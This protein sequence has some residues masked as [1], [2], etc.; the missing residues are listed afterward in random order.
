MF[1]RTLVCLSV[2]LSG[3]FPAAIIAAPV[4][5]DIQSYRTPLSP[6]TIDEDLLILR[7][8]IPELARRM[9][10]AASTRPSR[11]GPDTVD[12][13]LSRGPRPGPSVGQPSESRLLINGDRYLQA[14]ETFLKWR[15]EFET[16]WG[17]TEVPSWEPKAVGRTPLQKIFADP[18]LD[19]RGKAMAMLKVYYKN[20][21]RKNPVSDP[22][23]KPTPTPP[24]EFWPVSDVIEIPE[25]NGSVQFNLRGHKVTVLN[26]ATGEASV[27]PYY[28]SQDPRAWL[29]TFRRQALK[30]GLARAIE[31]EQE[32]EIE[33]A[34][35]PSAA[36]KAK[37]A[38]KAP[39]ESPTPVVEPVELPPQEKP[40]PQ[41]PWG[42]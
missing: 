20:P 36:L 23:L 42:E 29:A 24:P 14:T 26:E 1:S 7:E 5:V 13:R 28:S 21:I 39:L 10:P 12:L 25:V 33:R 40:K 38:G 17:Q 16:N 30:H 22:K 6:G 2:L 4:P 35:L 8:I 27:I 18:S 32:K 9:F 34:S 3:I 15:K 37:V 11:S 41:I 19:R 31:M